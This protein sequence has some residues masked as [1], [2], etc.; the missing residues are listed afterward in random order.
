VYEHPNCQFVA[1][2]IGVTNLLTGTV[3][4]R[5]EGLASVAG[6]ISESRF[7]SADISR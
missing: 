3:A 6:F 4:A 7:S 5:A 2:F 1:D